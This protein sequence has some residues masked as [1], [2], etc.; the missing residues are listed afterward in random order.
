[1]SYGALV[2]GHALDPFKTKFLRLNRLAMN[3]FCSIPKSTPTKSLELMLN[4]MLLNIFCEKEGLTA[5]LRLNR[6]LEFGWSGK[7]SNKTYSTSHMKFW[8]DKSNEIPDFY[9]GNDRTKE[10]IWE[11]NFEV[12]LTSF[13]E[14]GLITYSEYNIFSDG[15]K[16]KDNVGAGFVV[17]KGN[18]AIAKRSFKLPS[19]TTVF[20]A[21]VVAI[22]RALEL[23]QEESI[24]PKFMKIFIDSQAAILA[25]SNPVLSSKLVVR[26]K[27]LLNVMSSQTKIKLMWTKAHIGT[28]GNEIADSLA[29]EGGEK[30]IN[31]VID[32][33]F[34]EIKN[35]ILQKC[36]EKW[37][38]SWTE[39]KGGEWR[40][41]LWGSQTRIKLHT[42]LNYPRIS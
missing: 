3:T 40:N 12:D 41:S 37:E 28:E 24:A 14:K 5:F 17:M 31:I 9:E 25:I 30:G 23:I 20:Q 38:K 7:Y 39:Y 42:Y 21:E 36:N 35:Q 1:M 34:L 4:I 18:L 16:I 15:S 6:V 2:W 33:P 22:L 26:T 13:K 8:M 27:I 19:T 29:K 11:K 10:L 32:T